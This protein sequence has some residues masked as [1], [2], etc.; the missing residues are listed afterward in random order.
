MRESTVRVQEW[1]LVRV[2]ALVHE[3]MLLCWL[4]ILKQLHVASAAWMTPTVGVALHHEQHA[5][6]DYTSC[7]RVTRASAVHQ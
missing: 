3:L 5:D 6:V 7:V 1:A 4:L 2:S